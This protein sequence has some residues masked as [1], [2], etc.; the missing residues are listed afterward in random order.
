M[1]EKLYEVIRHLY[2]DIKTDEYGQ[3][4][5]VLVFISRVE[6][7]PTEKLS[8]EE[9]MAVMR[10]DVSI[11]VHF[12]SSEPKEYPEFERAISSHPIKLSNPSRI[13]PVWIERMEVVNLRPFEVV[14]YLRARDFVFV[15]VDPYTRGRKRELVV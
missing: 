12:Y 10:K 1:V 15:D 2:P 13:V 5:S 14:F 4:E 11:E 9:K 7:F 3:P 6:Y 8:D